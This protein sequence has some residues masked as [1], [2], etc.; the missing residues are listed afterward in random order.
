MAPRK[1]PK[2]PTN[3]KP[4]NVAK[5][6]S[7]R[8]SHLLAPPSARP[9]FHREGG[10]PQLHRPAPITQPGL[11]GHRAVGGGGVGAH[12][13]AVTG[14]RRGPGPARAPGGQR[15][16][17][18]RNGR[19]RPPRARGAGRA[20]AQPPEEG[21]GG[22]SDV[23]QP[24]PIG[25][26]RRYSR[27]CVLYG[28]RQPRCLSAGEAA[29]MVSSSAAGPQFS[30][31]GGGVAV[32]PALFPAAAVR[33]LSASAGRRHAPGQGSGRAAARSSPTGERRPIVRGG[34]G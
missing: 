33:R 15:R 14:G 24:P 20:A 12:A 32:W 21:A 31:A 34:R 17:S 11:R 2:Q 19:H 25:A 30:R 7:H 1:K 27:G 4:P 16:L 5:S 9:R 23:R 18:P 3:P 6:P 10:H 26:Q 22:A 8:P 13:Q 28:N 29:A